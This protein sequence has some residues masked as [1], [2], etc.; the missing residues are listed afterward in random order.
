MWLRSGGACDHRGF[1]IHFT[2]RADLRRST[3]LD[4]QREGEANGGDADEDRD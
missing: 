4:T 2:R 1:R 3:G